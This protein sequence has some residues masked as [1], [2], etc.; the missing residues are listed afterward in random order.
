M[1]NEN[2]IESIIHNSNILFITLILSGLSITTEVWQWENM[3]LK[4]IRGRFLDISWGRKSYC[5]ERK[6]TCKYRSRV[7]IRK[8]KSQS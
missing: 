1:K 2:K 3:G 6:Y 4:A 8:H 7:D 5:R